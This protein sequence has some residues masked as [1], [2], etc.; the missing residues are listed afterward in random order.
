M[1]D[2]EE[3]TTETT[4]VT[5][6]AALCDPAASEG[7]TVFY[8]PGPEDLASHSP[9]GGEAGTAYPATVTYVHTEDTVNVQVEFPGGTQEFQARPYGNNPGEW[10]RDAGAADGDAAFTGSLPAEG[11]WEDQP[12][13]QKYDDRA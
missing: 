3:Q 13:E 2:H 6:P 4:D 11:N 12:G 7:E 9:M 8:R 10:S 5:A 1:T